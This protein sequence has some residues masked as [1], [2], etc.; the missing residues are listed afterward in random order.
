ME[1]VEVGLDG[2]LTEHA[3]F[4]VH[5]RTSRAEQRTSCF[6]RESHGDRSASLALTGVEI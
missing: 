4:D 6:S 1:D 5:R 3:L 2:V